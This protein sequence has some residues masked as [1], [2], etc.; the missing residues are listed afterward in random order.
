MRFYSL[1][2]RLKKEEQGVA[3][4]EFAL[5]L[6]LLTLILFGSIEVSNLLVADA[7][8]RAATSSV[9]DMLTQITVTTMTQSDLND[10]NTAVTEIMK[11]LPVVAG[12]VDLLGMRV[13]N[14][15]VDVAAGGVVKVRWSRL[16]PNIANTSV[17]EVTLSN[18]LC[19]NNGPL[20]TGLSSTS[21]DVMRTTGV[22][23]WRPWFTTVFRTSPIYLRAEY[24]NMPRY[25]TRIDMAAAAGGNC[26]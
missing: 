25:V 3:A 16:L 23:A 26:V 20:P 8:I 7:R 10:A 21:N 6:P 18:P 24:F 15:Y 17:N 4:T 9:S 14:F 11:P 2:R 12:A 5:I 13:T 19:S 1:L 22:Y